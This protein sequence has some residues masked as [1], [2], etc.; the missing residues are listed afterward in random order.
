MNIIKN[1]ML[2]IIATASVSLASAAE[3]LG[4]GGNCP[5]CY[6]AVEK[7]VEGKESITSV[8]EG[9]T[10]R[11]VDE[12]TKAKF[13]AAPATYL[14]QYNGHCAYGMSLGKKFDGD[15]AIFKVIDG[16]LFLN[17]NKDVAKLFAK[18]TESQIVKA[19]ENW[20]KMMIK[21]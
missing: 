16:R 13:E 5:V 2:L 17:L 8:H 19:D 9:V 18:D 11:F 21:K 12:A 15:P 20:K 6:I 7:A 14:P 4:L 10:Y 3:K 1:T